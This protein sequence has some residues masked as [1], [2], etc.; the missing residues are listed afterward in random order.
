MK[1]IKV[2]VN[3]KLL[4]LQITIHLNWNKYIIQMFPKSSGACY[5]IRP[6]VHI[7]NTEVSK[8]IYFVCFQSVMKCRIFRRKFVVQ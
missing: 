1:C 5:V 8:V 3:A 6:V 4:G 2:S 7:I